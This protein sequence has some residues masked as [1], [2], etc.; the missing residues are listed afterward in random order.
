[1]IEL[2]DEI[3]NKIL[4]Q[5]FIFET[6]NCA[7]FLFSSTKMTYFKE[8]KR[9]LCMSLFVDNCIRDILKTAN[10]Y[11]DDLKKSKENNQLLI[12]ENS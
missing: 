1:M 4:K 12:N 10:N 2:T 8:T 11:Q 9:K 7:V 5:S 6:K 3:A